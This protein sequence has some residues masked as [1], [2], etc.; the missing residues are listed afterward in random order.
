M[1]EFIREYGEVVIAVLVCSIL[2]TIA[3][4]VGP[5]LKDAMVEMVNSVVETT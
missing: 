1:S 3:L 5:D 2:L 4:S